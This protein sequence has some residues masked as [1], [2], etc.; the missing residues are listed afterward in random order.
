MNSRWVR[1]STLLGGV[2]ALIYLRGTNHG[3]EV[4]V[5]APADID[6]KEIVLTDSTMA[7]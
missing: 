6:P 5:F 3:S 1:K 4:G 7:R 2:A